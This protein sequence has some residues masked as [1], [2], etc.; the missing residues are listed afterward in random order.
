LLTKH[1]TNDESTICYFF[2]ILFSFWVVN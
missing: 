2:K 1:E